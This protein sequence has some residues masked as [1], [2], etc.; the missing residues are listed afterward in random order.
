VENFFAISVGL[1]N[2]QNINK[3]NNIDVV[4]KE[5][6]NRLC[7]FDLGH[8]TPDKFKLDKKTFLLKSTSV[9]IDVLLWLVNV[10][11]LR[12]IKKSSPATFVMIPK[13][14]EKLGIEE[15]A[16]ALKMILDKK[17]EILGELDKISNEFS[18]NPE[19]KKLFKI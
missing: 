5:D 7:L 15:R 6:E 17:H 18:N 2:D 10:L 16:E 1:L 4:S 9:L 8:P 3:E 11:S 13:I 19:M 12:R 14:K